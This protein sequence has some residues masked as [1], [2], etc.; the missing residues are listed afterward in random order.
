MLHILAG[1]WQELILVLAAMQ[2]CGYKLGKRLPFSARPTVT[3]PATEHHCPLAS[4]KSYCLVIEAQVFK[5]LSMKWLG[6][7]PAN[8]LPS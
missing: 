6:V 2:G 7:K 8:S 4:T 1:L 3:F 5:Q